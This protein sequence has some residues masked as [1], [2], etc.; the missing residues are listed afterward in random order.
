MAPAITIGQKWLRIF[1]TLPQNAKPLS[2][3]LGKDLEG[4]MQFQ[5]IFV[6]DQRGPK[7]KL[8]FV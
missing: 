4:L 8:L 1:R 3:A 6:G 5:S 7:S 2:V